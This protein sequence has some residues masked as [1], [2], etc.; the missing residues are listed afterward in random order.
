MRWG[1]KGQKVRHVI[2]AEAFN[3]RSSREGGCRGVKSRSPGR[4][5]RQAYQAAEKDY[6]LKS[7]N[8]KGSRSTTT[9]VGPWT[10]LNQCDRPC[11]LREQRGKN[12]GE[13]TVITSQ[14]SGG[15]A[16]VP[17]TDRGRNSTVNAIEKKGK[18]R[19]GGGKRMPSWGCQGEET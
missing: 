14:L 9:K 13:W 12:Q 3:P 2:K 11:S 7:Q 16:G 17:H 6:E 19:G 5:A 15:R 18:A 4:V 10:S 8:T 1:G